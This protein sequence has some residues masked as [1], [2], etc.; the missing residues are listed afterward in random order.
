MASTYRCSSCQQ[1]LTADKFHKNKKSSN[2]LQYYCKQC[3]KTKSAER[4]ANNPEYQ[5]QKSKEFKERNP[6]YHK[7]YYEDNKSKYKTKYKHTTTKFR[8][9][10]PDYHKEYYQK[11][12]E[13]RREYSKSY[14]V[15]NPDVSFTGNSKRRAIINKVKHVKYSRESIFIRDNWICQICC[16]AVNPTFYYQDPDPEKSAMSASIDHIIL[17]AEGGSD[18]YDNV[19]LAHLRCN[20]TRS[21]PKKR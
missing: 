15:R 10:N 13:Q 9:K 11:N 18:T 5:K 12:R 17:I 20:L 21:K 3:M 8:I 4:R 1:Y 19:R 14:R 2:G 16:H 7:K 6:D